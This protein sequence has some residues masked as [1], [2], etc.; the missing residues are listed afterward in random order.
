[1]EGWHNNRYTNPALLEQVKEIKL[2]SDSNL[3]LSKYNHVEVYYLYTLAGVGLEPT[4]P[5]WGAPAYETGEIPTSRPR[6]IKKS[7]SVPEC[8]CFEGFVLFKE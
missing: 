6:D 5:L 8:H 7:L 3:A 1:M 2:A 4:T